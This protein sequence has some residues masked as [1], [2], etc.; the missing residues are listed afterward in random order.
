MSAPSEVGDPDLELYGAKTGNCL[1]AAIGL[2]EAALPYRVRHIDLR[3][4]E[5]RGPAHQALNPAGKVPVL[6]ARSS[7]VAPTVLTQSNAILFYA[8][9]RSPDR[10]LPPQGTL[11][12]VRALEAFFYF[13]N[14]VIALNGAAFSLQFQGQTD[15]AALLTERYLAAITASERFLSETGFMGG[16]GFSIADIAAFTIVTAIKKHLPWERLPHLAA[17]RERIGRRPAVQTGMASFDKD[18]IS[19]R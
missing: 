2:S 7:G 8:A 19:T 13:T 5:Q 10:L 16:D 14:D 1:R 15:A 17:W 6:V 12:R 9:E 11:S 4:G 18:E 3:S